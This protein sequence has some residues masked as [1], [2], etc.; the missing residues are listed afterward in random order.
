M[1]T[2]IICKIIGQKTPGFN[3]SPCNTP[4]DYKVLEAGILSHS[5]SYSGFYISNTVTSQKYKKSTFTQLSSVTSKTFSI[6]QLKEVFIRKL[7]NSEFKLSQFMPQLPITVLLC[8]DGTLVLLLL[9]DPE[10]VSGY[11]RLYVTL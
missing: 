7:L 10:I 5:S 6:F 11:R 9:L 4:L 1:S 3:T 2:S 8:G